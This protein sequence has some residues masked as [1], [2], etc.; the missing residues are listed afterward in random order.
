MSSG[1]I[2]SCISENKKGL[3]WRDIHQYVASRILETQEVGE[4]NVVLG[5]FV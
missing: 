4:L 5:I 2:V 3:E 1:Q